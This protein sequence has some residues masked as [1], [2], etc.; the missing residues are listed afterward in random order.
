MPTTWLNWSACL[1]ESPELFFP[2]GNTDPA[3][4]Q[5]K[6]AKAVRGRCEVVEDCL[7]W[8]IEYGQDEVCGAAVRH[9][10]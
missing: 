6:A 7:N 9:A 8:A 5:F 4:D 10:S 1:D 2:I 3:L